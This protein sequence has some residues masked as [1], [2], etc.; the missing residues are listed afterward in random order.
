MGTIE[1]DLDG[2][3]GILSTTCDTSCEN[4]PQVPVKNVAQNNSYFAHVRLASEN[5][6]KISSELA[7]STSVS[8]LNRSVCSASKLDKSLAQVSELTKCASVSEDVKF[9][10]I[11]K[12]TKASEVSEFI[13]ASPVSECVKASPVPELAKTSSVSDLGKRTQVSE[14]AKSGPEPLLMSTTPGAQ[15]QEESDC[16]SSW[17]YYTDTEDEDIE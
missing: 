2:K 13:K 9:S 3:I 14:L 10:P 4:P 12:C 11:S 1:E 17:E 5:P 8:E 16:E 7:K 6:F 15:N